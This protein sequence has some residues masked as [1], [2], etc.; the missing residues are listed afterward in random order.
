M[1]KTYQ[2]PVAAAVEFFEE[3][4]LLQTSPG[5]EI[6]HDGPQVD[7]GSSYTQRRGMFSA[8]PWEDTTEE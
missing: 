5:V 1:K 3:Q 8:A 7:A 4:A 2:T 6:K